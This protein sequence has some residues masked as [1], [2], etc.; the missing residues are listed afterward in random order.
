[1]STQETKKNKTVNK[2]V[3]HC[4]NDFHFFLPLGSN[5]TLLKQH[6]LEGDNEQYS[7]VHKRIII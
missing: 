6:I 1:M 3:S 4:F 7:Q 2:F 5:R